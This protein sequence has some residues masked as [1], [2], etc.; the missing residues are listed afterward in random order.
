MSD[1]ESDYYEVDS[2]T[3]GDF[4]NDSDEEIEEDRLERE[5]FDQLDYDPNKVPWD[6]QRVTT[7]IRPTDRDPVRGSSGLGPAF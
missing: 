5:R 1:E 7:E 6:W 4:E 3:D 2:D